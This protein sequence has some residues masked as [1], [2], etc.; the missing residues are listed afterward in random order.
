MKI[1]LNNPDYLYTLTIPELNKIA[2]EKGVRFPENYSGSY[3]LELKKN[4]DY[5]DAHSFIRFG[6]EQ[7]NKEWRE[8]N[9]EKFDI[10]M[11]KVNS[12]YYWYGIYGEEKAKEVCLI[13]NKRHFIA[14]ILSDNPKFPVLI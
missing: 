8:D 13:L 9:K 2:R 4:L 6:H 11:I 7:M 1:D 10:H 14:A 5:T 12:N 3:S